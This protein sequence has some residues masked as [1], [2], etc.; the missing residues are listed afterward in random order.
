MR[1]ILR[2]DNENNSLIF[3]G[4]VPMNT[5]FRFMKANFDKL[6]DAASNAAILAS[7]F[8]ASIQPQYVLIISCVG[9][10]LF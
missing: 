5:S 3:A 10:K 8:H 2:I 1:T 7:S 9:R 4:D 6:I